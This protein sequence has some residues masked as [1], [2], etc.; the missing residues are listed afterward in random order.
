MPLVQSHRQLWSIWY[1]PSAR[2]SM[3]L[4]TEPPL[5]PLVL[6][7]EQLWACPSPPWLI[8]IVHQ[9]KPFL[10]LV[11]LHP[12]FW[13]RRG[14]SMACSF[15]RPACQRASRDPP[16]SVS[17][18]TAADIMVRLPCLAFDIGSGYL[19]SGSHNWEASMLPSE[20]LSQPSVI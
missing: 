7:Y 20:P 8:I 15:I 12:T 18:H 5:Q 13:L 2:E 4:T 3:L 17:H 1:V 9:H 19:N 11:I 16:A 14:L 10:C 6:L